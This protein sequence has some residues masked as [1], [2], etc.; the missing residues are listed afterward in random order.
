MNIPNITS[1]NCNSVY[2]PNRKADSTQKA[3]Y[4]EVMITQPKTARDADD[5]IG[6]GTVDIS[7]GS[8][9]AFYD[10]HSSDEEPI[11]VITKGVKG[12]ELIKI[13]IN[14]IDPQNATKY[15]MFALCSYFDDKGMTAPST[16]GSFAT[17]TAVEEMAS[18]NMMMSTSEGV[19][20]NNESKKFNWIKMIQDVADMVFKCKDMDQYMKIKSLDNAIKEMS[21]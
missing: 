16:F 6:F 15:E 17:L 12:E 11:V 3:S 1:Q 18:H 14:D 8:V 20:S 13:S 10:I 9:T 21:M 7:L 5:C 19:V 4:D 2:V